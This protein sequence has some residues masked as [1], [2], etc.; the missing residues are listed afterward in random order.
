MKNLEDKKSQRIHAIVNF[1]ENLLIRWTYKKNDKS[2]N[3]VAQRQ[4]ITG[5]NLLKG[6]RILSF[7]SNDPLSYK[8]REIL[9]TKL[10]FTNFYEDFTLIKMIGKGSFSCVFNYF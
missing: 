1:D 10:K 6:S 3:A 2:K 8:F 7:K 4:N 5:F 9:K